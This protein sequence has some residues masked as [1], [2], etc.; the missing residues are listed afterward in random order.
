MLKLV[1]ADEAAALI[2]DDVNL[3]V[4][5][6]GAYSAPDEI[7]GGIERRFSACGHPKGLTVIS[8]VCT[9][10]NGFDDIGHNRI[11]REGLIN[12]V[13][14]GHFKNSAAMDRLVSENRVAG[15]TLPLGVIMNLYRAAAAKKPGILTRVGLNTY[16][17]PR[18]GGCAV[19]Q[20]AA[21]QHRNLT[22]VV[23]MDGKD[24]LFY[25]TI[26]IDACVIRGTYADEDGNIS[27]THEAI[28]EAQLE[29]AMAAHNS[30]GIVIVQVEG[31]VK[32][33][34][35]PTREVRIHHSLV[36][37]VV[38]SSQENHMQNYAVDRYH[39]EL[40]GEIRIPLSEIKPLPL[41]IRKVIARRAVM[42][43]K[44]N[45]VINLGIGMPSGVG[46]VA[47]EEGLASAT[48]LSLESGPMGGVPVEG[49][50]FSGAANPEVINAITNNFDF[51]DGGG[52][53]MAF[54][55]VAEVDEN[56]DVNVS[57]FGASCAGPGGFINITQNTPCVCFMGGFTATKPQL[58]IGDGRLKILQDGKGVKFV[59]KVQQVTFS[60]DFARETG[61]KVLYITERA[62]FSLNDRGITLVE[63][64]PGVDIEKDILCRMEFRPDIAEDLKT[65]DERIFRPEKMGLHF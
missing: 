36:D 15:Y 58:E 20:K 50:G 31:L 5:G 28:Q 64:A 48:T 34:N 56:G 49:V 60:A 32:R 38:V 10:N 9:G 37:Y 55:G 11:C 6:F 26:P 7:L 12:T 46:N 52:L 21:D 63:V 16:I 61:Q 39:P 53:N 3:V 45:S 35:I 1:T 51:Y 8:G 59:H 25:K 30:G 14:A 44:Q 54:L 65:M 57:K 29:I 43:L 41:N 19:N 40:S 24:Y 17:D 13:I 4:G 27:M 33:G 47:N 2:K 62:V 42:E 22:A 23:T 18:H